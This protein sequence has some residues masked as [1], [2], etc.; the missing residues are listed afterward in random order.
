M[1]GSSRPEC[2]VKRLLLKVLQNSQ[3]KTFAGV[4]FLKK[5]AGF[6]QL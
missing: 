5:V 1:L 2:S 4:P 6:L 3:G